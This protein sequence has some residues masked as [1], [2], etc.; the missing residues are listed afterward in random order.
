MTD[1]PIDNAR[2]ASTSFRDRMREIDAKIDRIQA[3]VSELKPRLNESMP[4]SR[5]IR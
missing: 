3:K 2:G 4:P 1:G 5:L